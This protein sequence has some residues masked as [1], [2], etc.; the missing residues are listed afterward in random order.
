MG[1]LLI[2][3]YTFGALETKIYAYGE[4]GILFLPCF[5]TGRI[6]YYSPFCLNALLCNFRLELAP[7]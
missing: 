5:A 1:F 3:I 6:R 2:F 4:V 7:A